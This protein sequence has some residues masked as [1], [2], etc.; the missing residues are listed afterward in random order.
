[1]NIISFHWL[2]NLFYMVVK[3]LL[4]VFIELLHT[5][6]KMN[7][8]THNYHNKSFNETRIDIWIFC[9]FSH[10][11]F[12]IAHFPSQS[13]LVMM[14]ELCTFFYL[15]PNWLKSSFIYV[16]CVYSSLPINV[17]SNFMF[18]SNICLRKRLRSDV[19]FFDKKLFCDFVIF[20]W[21]SWGKI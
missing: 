9:S 7:L 2:H 10:P 8:L 6:L 20:K 18:F 12:G 14:S 21:C 5:F 11:P 1:M 3:K 15:Y 4:P 16:K 13:P 17:I 19:N